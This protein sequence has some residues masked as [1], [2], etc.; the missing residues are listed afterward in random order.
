MTRRSPRNHS[1]A[2]L[3]KVA[4]AATRGEKTLSE[5]AEQFGVLPNQ[6]STRREPLLKGPSD[7][8]SHG[9]KSAPAAPAAHV[10]TLHVC[11]A[12]TNQASV[13]SAFC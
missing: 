2:C 11:R 1:A 12:V 10:K 6:F 9:E 7:V 8:F 13:A 3:A 4:L 5:F